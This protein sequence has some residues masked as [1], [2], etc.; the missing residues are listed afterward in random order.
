MEK[1]RGFDLATSSD[2]NNQDL[3]TRNPFLFYFFANFPVSII[4]RN[5]VRYDHYQ[6]KKQVHDQPY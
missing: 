3:K 1:V 2:N 5:K 6:E 4:T